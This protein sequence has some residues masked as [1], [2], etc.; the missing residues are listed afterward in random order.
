MSVTATETTPCFDAPSMAS[1]RPGEVDFDL[2]GTVG[3]R[4][5]NASPQAC[6]GVARLLGRPLAHRLGREPDIVIRFVD[7]RFDRS[8][9]RYA[10]VDAAFDDN[11]FFVL[12]RRGGTALATRLPCETLGERCQISCESGLRAVPLLVPIINLT[13]LGKGVLPVHGSAF[14][15]DGRGVLVVGWTKGGKTETL[16]AFMAHGAHYVGDEWVFISADGQRLFGLP[17]PVRVWDWHLRSVP[18]YRSRLSRPARSRLWCTRQAERVVSRLLVRSSGG[19]GRA[20]TLGRIKARVERELG[21]DVPPDR[22]FGEGRRVMS[23]GFD[24]LILAV[25]RE[26]PGVETARLR[27]ADVAAAMAFSLQAERTALTETYLR[28]RFAFPRRS[29]RLLEQAEALERDLL[30]RVFAGK[31]T[32]AVYHPSPMAIGDLFGVLGPLVAG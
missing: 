8:R 26:A 31:K 24:H 13:M 7:E 27:T 2:H 30:H 21:A 4:L 6:A 18:H 9:W 22:L 19:S 32:H 12:S 14:T 11:H 29:S 28:F 5:L 10:G 3:L 16:L 17:L 23:A 25:T 20:G 1:A 15:C